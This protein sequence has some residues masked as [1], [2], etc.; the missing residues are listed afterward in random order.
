MRSFCLRLDSVTSSKTLAAELHHINGVLLYIYIQLYIHIHNYIYTYTC[1]YTSIYTY[2]LWKQV[3][4]R[5]C[6]STHRSNCIQ[7]FRCPVPATRQKS[8]GNGRPSP[9]LN[10][11]T[12][13]QPTKFGS[14]PMGP[15]LGQPPSLLPLMG[16]PIQFF[17]RPHWIQLFSLHL[18][19]LWVPFPQPEKL[20]SFRSVSNIPVGT[21]G[22]SCRFARL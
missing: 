10:C 5:F 18:I 20:G 2:L 17:L 9:F 4:P 11:G 14:Q 8:C 12:G 6:W 7:T 1:I 22:Q 19:C 16:K 15:K 3:E 13:H 21:V